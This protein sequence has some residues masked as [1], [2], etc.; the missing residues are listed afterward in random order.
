MVQLLESNLEATY[1]VPAFQDNIW[2]WDYF[3]LSDLTEGFPTVF[4][5]LDDGI[6]KLLKG[7]SAQS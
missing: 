3:E 2:F 5:F 6:S 7:Q 4:F 1:N